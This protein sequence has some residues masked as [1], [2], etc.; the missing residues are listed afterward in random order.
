MAAFEF[1]P[2]PAIAALVAPRL[3]RESRK[4][5]LRRRRFSPEPGDQA[6]FF[7]E[8]VLAF[9]AETG[10]VGHKPCHLGGRGLVI[11]AIGQVSQKNITL[12]DSPILNI[13]MGDSAKVALLADCIALTH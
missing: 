8:L 12:A 11:A 9:R 1:L 7:P 10:L 3:A 2:R 6:S 13:S 4:L 5:P